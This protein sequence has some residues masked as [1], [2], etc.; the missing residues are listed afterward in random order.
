LAITFRVR[1]VPPA[2]ESR[3][4]ETIE[5]SLPGDWSVTLSRSH[6]DGQ[7]H[8]QLEGAPGRY[9]VVLPSLEDVRFGSLGRLLQALVEDVNEAPPTALA[10]HREAEA[11][12][13]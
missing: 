3:F 11:D 4:L 12:R 13:P 6:L 9:R 5:E 10:P 1:D 7:W 2:L 8:L